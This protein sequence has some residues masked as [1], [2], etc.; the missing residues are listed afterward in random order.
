MLLF[1]TTIFFIT[2]CTGINLVELLFKSK[3]N[4]AKCFARCQS[5]ETELE[6]TRCL[7]LCDV[8]INNPE[9]EDICSLSSVCSGGCEVACDTA[10]DDLEK[11]KFEAG[12]LDRCQLSWNLEKTGGD[13]VFLI[14]GRD[15][16]G[17]WNLI[18]NTV[19][20]TS[21]ELSYTLAAKMV[22]IQIFA[23]GAHDVHDVTSVDVGDNQCQENVPQPLE[24]RE[25]EEINLE[26]EHDVLEGLE[27]IIEKDMETII[28][29]NTSIAATVVLAL[30]SMF[31]I[32]FTVAIIIVRHRQQKTKDVQVDQ[33]YET[34]PELP[35]SPPVRSA[36]EVRKPHHGVLAETLLQPRVISTIMESEEYEDIE[37]S[38]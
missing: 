37:V 15:Q 16:A 18:S 7:S 35:Y 24:W 32:F 26:E 14:A 28:K 30:L 2:T 8:L 5:A 27:V 33:F 23:V 6:R 25:E 9:D 20:D 4:E 22:E 19:V 10:D 36:L 1:L 11:T 29:E 21:M 34:V 12:S 13:V 3:I 38:S 31:A 17:M